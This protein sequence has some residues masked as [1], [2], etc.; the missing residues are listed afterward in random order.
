MCPRR[1]RTRELAVIVALLGV[2][3]MAAPVT[4]SETGV[5]DASSAQSADDG[6]NRTFN[7]T[8]IVTATRTPDGG[9]L[10]GGSTGFRDGDGTLLKLAANGS[11]A[12]TRSYDTA[13]RSGIAALDTG[14]NGNVYFLQYAYEPSEDGF[15]GYSVWLVSATEAGEVRWREPLNRSG[16]YGG[17]G[18]AVGADGPALIGPSPD[19]EAVTLQQFG[20]DGD[21]RWNRTYEIDASP[22]TIEA[23]GDG[24]LIAGTV[25]YEHPWVL[26]TGDDG[27]VE[28]NRTYESSRVERLAGVVPTDDGYLVA[29]AYSADH[30]GQNP[31]AAKLGRDGVARWSRVYPQADD[32]QVQNAFPDGDGITLVGGGD[33]S[34][35]EDASSYLVG[36]GPNG[37]ERFSERVDGARS[38][39]AVPGSNR[40]VTLVGIQGYPG[41][42]GTVSSSVL[43]MTLPENATDQEESPIE[44]LTSG[45][46]YYRGQ[47]LEFVR[48][49]AAG[50]TVDLV[51]VPGE[52]DDFDPHVVRR[53]ELD[54]DG[55]VIVESATLER[56][57]YYLQTSDGSPIRSTSG[58][59]LK[60]SDRDSA[61][62]QLET[63]ELHRGYYPGREPKQYV[64]RAA[65]ESNATLTIESERQNYDLLVS[66]D[67][68]RG[69]EVGAETLRN[70]FADESVSIEQFRGTTV[71]RLP[72]SGTENLTLTVDDVDAG[73]YDFTFRGADTSEGGA[74]A[75]RRLVIGA[76]TPRPVSFS[77]RNT[78]L[79]VPVGNETA[80]NV[81]LH[82]VTAGVGAMSMSANRTGPPAIG[83]SLD[84]DVNATSMQAGSSWGD[85]RSEADAQVFDAN[86]ANGTVE[87]GTLSVTAD[88]LDPESQPTNT[89]TV[90]LDWVVDENGVPYTLPGETTVTVRVENI[91][92]ATG[93]YHERRG[94]TDHGVATSSGTVRAG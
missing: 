13:N 59:A 15:G 36:V 62:F 76:E 84:L 49:S 44:P 67:R 45:E 16:H 29:G 14:P 65:G 2:A 23:H 38:T 71:A 47:D 25:G 12:W 20:T 26:E 43:T 92:N 37:N 79:S 90:R 78:T 68:F 82:D 63:Q 74:V 80:T 88:N 54:G 22:Q 89:V 46:T 81:T 24:Y 70:L 5:S 83:L 52:Y 77:L 21:L 57:T 72:A 91:E 6:S 60:E 4:A 19:R 86:T 32:V 30:H 7:D 50:E 33:M 51:V 10:L 11:T 73:L 58:W 85:H 69:D 55:R 35:P 87:I 75:E 42:S 9:V 64:D 40:Q 3:A 34:D 1:L 17:G 39:V 94:P 61:T 31:W 93:E 8:A 28:A 41:P 18:F 27:A 53:V 56:G 66:A 48:P